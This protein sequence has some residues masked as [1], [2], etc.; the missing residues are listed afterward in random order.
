MDSILEDDIQAFR[1]D[2]AHKLS[3]LHRN[4]TEWSPRNSPT[5]GNSRA[6]FDKRQKENELL[7]QKITEMQQEIERKRSSSPAFEN[8]SNT[9][10]FYPM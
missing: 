1:E 2:S 4:D 9:R 8:E 7:M 3:T 5:A 6:E 10:S